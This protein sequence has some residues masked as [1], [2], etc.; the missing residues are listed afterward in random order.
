MRAR[1]E[2]PL[3][4]MYGSRARFREGQWEAISTFTICG[5]LLRE[6]GSGPVYPLAMVSAYGG[7]DSE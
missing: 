1:A 4:Q 3:K 2:H 6:S 5:A 7:G